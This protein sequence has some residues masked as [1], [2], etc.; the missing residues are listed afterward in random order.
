MKKWI[1]L[2]LYLIIEFNCNAQWTLQPGVGMAIPITGYSTIVK[3]GTLLQFDAARRLNNPRWGIGLMLGW[4]RM[5]HDDNEADLLRDARLDQ[6]PILATIDHQFRGQKL[7]PYIGMGIGVSL[8]NL[9]YVPPASAGETVF[10]ASF[11]L[12]PRL[13]LRG[14]LNKNFI[15]FL[16]VNC[17][18]VMDGPPVGVSQ[19]EK[20]TG[21]VGIAVGVAYHL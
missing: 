14:R 20:V 13:G 8:Y 3:T 2:S 10:N 15:P 7:T 6:I 11:S 18:L 1:L 4:A 19:G 12:M 17:P 5:H 16:E 21:Y 9:N